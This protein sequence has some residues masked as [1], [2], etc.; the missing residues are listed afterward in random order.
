MVIDFYDDLK[1]MTSGFASLD[2]EPAED[3]EADVVK[4]DLLLNG[5]PLDAL[6]FVCHRTKAETMGRDIV[7][8]L[9]KV[10][11]RQQFE[12][13]IQAS[14]GLKVFA[15]ER[16]APYRKNVLIKGGKTVGG[17]DVTRKKKLLEKQKK[18]KAK[19]KL[20]GK[21]P[22]SQKAFWTVMQKTG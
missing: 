22:L 14:L 20:V 19:A 13:T 7:R 3:L 15:K 10:I 4:V 1:S 17:G 8:R 18:G 21:V 16:I 12:V 11:E 5:D 6:S 9:K 2:Y